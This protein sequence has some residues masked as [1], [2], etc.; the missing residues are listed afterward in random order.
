MKKSYT[1]MFTDLSNAKIY[2]YIIKTRMADD[3]VS[4][5]RWKLNADRVRAGKNTIRQADL[6]KEYTVLSEEIIPK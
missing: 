4:A 1:V 3:V 2:T 6:L 5:A